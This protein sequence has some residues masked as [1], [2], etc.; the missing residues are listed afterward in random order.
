MK[1]IAFK[2]QV[3]FLLKH[4]SDNIYLPSNQFQSSP[5]P[6]PYLFRLNYQNSNCINIM[7]LLSIISVTFAFCAIG[8]AVA[9][10]LPNINAAQDRS[11]SKGASGWVPPRTV[12]N[13]KTGKDLPCLPNG[14]M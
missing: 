5:Q 3:Y 4:L 1:Q 7:K 6:L 13:P 10:P 2:S 8:V 12:K 11:P 9:L 14:G